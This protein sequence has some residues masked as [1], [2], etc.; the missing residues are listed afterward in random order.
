MIIIEYCPKCGGKPHAFMG[1]ER[2]GY[3][4]VSTT[5]NY[6]IGGSHPDETDAKSSVSSMQ[7]GSS[8]S[9]REDD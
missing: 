5:C 8:A 6:T 3:E 1:N 7:E 2:D 4:C 9:V